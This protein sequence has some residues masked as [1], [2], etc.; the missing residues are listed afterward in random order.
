MGSGFDNLL[1]P[2]PRLLWWCHELANGLEQGPDTL[3][4]TLDSAFQIGEAGGQLF[5]Q[6]QGF[7]SSPSR[8]AKER[9]GDKERW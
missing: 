4:V 1:S 6:A 3:I 9:Q 5:V 8:R 2:P 7:P